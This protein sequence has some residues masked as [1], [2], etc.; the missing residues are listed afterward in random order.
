MLPGTSDDWRARLKL[1]AH[2]PVKI[3][4]VG[5][6]TD[7]V[8]PALQDVTVELRKQDL[9]VEVTEGEDGR[10]RLRVGHGEKMDFFYSVRLQPQEPPTFALQDPLRPVTESTRHYRA[11]VY[12][13]EGGQDYDVMGWPKVQL[14]RD[15]LDQ[16]ERH[17][18]FLDHV[19]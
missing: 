2:N 8:L 7:R 3:E 4:V 9:P 17:R 13:R 16:Y 6:I 14:I 1:L 12:L 15:V 10:A 19:R 5:L 18:Q 11:E